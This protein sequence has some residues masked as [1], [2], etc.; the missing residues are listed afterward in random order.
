VI[1][2]LALLVGLPMRNGIPG[3]ARSSH[4]H[5]APASPGCGTVAARNR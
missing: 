3:F 2:I 4:R 5:R 1:A